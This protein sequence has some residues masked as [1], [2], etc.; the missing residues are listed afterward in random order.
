MIYSRWFHSVN[1]KFFA[2]ENPQF[3]R[4]QK[5]Q[6]SEENTSILCTSC[7]TD[8][9][10]IY[11]AKISEIFNSEKNTYLLDTSPEFFRFH[12][13]DLHAENMEHAKRL[14]EALL[15][16]ETEYYISVLQRKTNVLS[17]LFTG[18]FQSVASFTEDEIQFDKF[19]LNYDGTSVLCRICGPLSQKLEKELVPHKDPGDVFTFYGTYRAHRLSTD[20]LIINHDGTDESDAYISYA[21]KLTDRE[22]SMINN[23]IN[24]YVQKETGLSPH[25]YIEQCYRNNIASALKNPWDFA[26]LQLRSDAGPTMYASFAEQKKDK[27]GKI[28]LMQWVKLEVNSAHW[29]ARNTQDPMIVLDRIVD[30]HNADPCYHDLFHPISV[31]DIIAINIKGKVEF[32]YCDPMG[33]TKI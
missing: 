12:Q 24:K 13:Y 23:A 19:G 7:S 4:V 30:N 22:L 25:E 28:D 2:D 16:R 32:W 18:L 5:W 9:E 15:L 33:F 27:D 10:P 6:D 20:L 3:L 1:P 11:I 21:R 8:Y 26:I 31:S 17:V 29:L 14:T